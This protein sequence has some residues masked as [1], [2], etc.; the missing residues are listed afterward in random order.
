MDLVLTRIDYGSDGVFGELADVN[1]RLL[2]YTAEHA[3][4]GKDGKEAKI[5]QG[6]WMCQR[7][8]HRLASMT[9]EFA[10]FQ[11]MNV[12]N[13]T[14]LLFHWGNYPQRDSDG[15]ILLGASIATISD[16]SRIITASRAAFAKFMDLQAELL[17][18]HLLVIP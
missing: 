11:I 17:I 14:N 9:Y 7:G 12:P 3:Y 1:G 16:G 15:C 6:T 2:A 13:H 5:P 18:F 8:M 10:T 4:D